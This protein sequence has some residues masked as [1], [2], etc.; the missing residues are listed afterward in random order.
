MGPISDFREGT[1]LESMRTKS[2]FIL[3]VTSLRVGIMK[4][5]QIGLLIH[6]AGV[7]SRC[8]ALFSL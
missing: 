4:R 6:V 5:C 2:C 1:V 3:L 7:H 8:G